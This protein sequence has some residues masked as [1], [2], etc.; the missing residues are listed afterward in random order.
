MSTDEKLLNDKEQKLLLNMTPVEVE[1]VIL[2]ARAKG[3]AWLERAA[4]IEEWSDDR[5]LRGRRRIQ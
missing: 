3:R 1:G 5:R 2:R 4:L